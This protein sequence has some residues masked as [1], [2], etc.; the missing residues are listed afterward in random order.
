M[1]RQASSSPPRH[2]EPPP[3]ISP[4]LQ[5]QSQAMEQASSSGLHFYQSAPMDP[6]E[7]DQNPD[8]PSTPH[9]SPQV[10]QSSQVGYLLSSPPSESIDI[11]PPADSVSLFTWF[12][13]SVMDHCY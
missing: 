5:H 12:L 2:L 1:D 8:L 3:M 4:N 7:P 6:C 11:V 10:A 9:E 13:F